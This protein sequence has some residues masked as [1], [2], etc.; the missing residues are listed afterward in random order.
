MLGLL[1]PLHNA[2]RSLRS[3]WSNLC[4]ES[5]HEAREYARGQKTCAS[6]L[7]TVAPTPHRPR[8]SKQR[9]WACTE[10]SHPRPQAA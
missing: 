2:L 10:K 5:E 4:C 6:R 3:L 1:A 9:A 8:A 7:R